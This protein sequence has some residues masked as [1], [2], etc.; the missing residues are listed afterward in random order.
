MLPIIILAESWKIQ[1]RDR[2]GPMHG[3]FQRHSYGVQ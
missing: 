3:T 2:D 1:C